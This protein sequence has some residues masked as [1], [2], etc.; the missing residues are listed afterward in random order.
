MYT[1]SALWTHARENLDITTII[2]NNRS[3]AILR[4]EMARVGAVTPG[5]GA[6]SLMDLTG[7]D[8]DFVHLSE[9]MGVPATRATTVEEL[10]TQFKAALAAPGPH[11]IEA[12]LGQAG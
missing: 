9:G 2:L 10:A 4:A 11:L 3:Y 1:L 5:P 6:S 8:L 12:V 7:P